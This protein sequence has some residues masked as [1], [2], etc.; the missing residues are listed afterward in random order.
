[1]LSTAPRQPGRALIAGLA[2][3]PAMMALPAILVSVPSLTAAEGG[4]RN[5]PLPDQI[6]DLLAEGVRQYRIG[7]YG[8][9]AN[10]FRKAVQLEPEHRLVYEFY[11]ACGEPLL[12]AMEAKNELDDVLKDLRR[13]ANIYRKDLHSDPKYIELMISKLNEGEDVRIAA[14][15]E[16][17]AIGP[18]AVPHLVAKIGDNRQDNLRVSSRIVLTRMGY[19]AVLPLIA[20]LDSSDQR[21]VATVAA[22]LADIGD[23]RAR[24][25][26]KRVAEHPEGDATTKQVA[27]N[28][29]AE[30]ARRS[31]ADATAEP[32]ALYLAEALRYFRGGEAIRDEVVANESLVWRWVESQAGGPAAQLTSVK[33]A[34]Y[35]WNELIAEE[36]LHLGMRAFPTHAPFQPLLAAVLAAQAAEAENRGILAKE[37]T[38]PANGPDER[39]DAIAERIAALAELPDRIRMAGPERLYR[40][41]DLCVRSERYDAAALILR[42]LQDKALAQP[43]RHLPGSGLPLEKAGSSLV[44]ALEHPEKLVRYE[45]AITLGHL[46]PA[47]EFTN[48]GKVVTALADAVGESGLRVVLVVDPDFRSRNQARAILQARGFHAT[49]A[50]DGHACLQRLRETPIVDAIIISGE[51]LP[52]L[53]G[54]HG[55]AIDVPEQTAPG[56]VGLL[57]SDTRT[58]GTPIFISLPEHPELAI[59]VKAGFEAKAGAPAA[60]KP[61]E[62]LAKPFVSEAVAGALDLALRDAQAPQANRDLAESLALRAALALAQPDPERTGLDLPAAV[63][64]LILTLENRRNELRIAACQ[65][66]SVIARHPAGSG[67]VKAQAEKLCALYTLQDNELPAAVR[68]ALIGAIGVADPTLPAAVQILRRALKHDD[69]SVRS[70]AHLAIGHA[71]RID[72][73]LL[74]DLQRQQRL[75][76]RSPGSG[77]A[78]KAAP[79]P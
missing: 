78:A 28:A 43:A 63:P 12:L 37:S 48:R 53:R 25:A 74:S 49:T 47:A 46:D 38:T 76:V 68:A 67:V 19:R 23:P 73:E 54:A 71:E 3:V 8:D 35:A 66:L 30:I 21:L 11:L 20:A 69:L 52:T 79:T 7:R 9:S 65:A 5:L 42:L 50:A 32:Q 18:R 13:R 57:R 4:D 59:R 17:I 31:G 60:G 29:L 75:D 55:E 64:A 34:R 56:L 16:L 22:V 10:T 70:A 6:R 62:F 77:V 15:Y 41:F 39:S 2:L 40:A 27:A 72:D 26:L 61:I 24:P 45:A 1:M 44:A 36:L 14:Q 33:V 51:L 58:A